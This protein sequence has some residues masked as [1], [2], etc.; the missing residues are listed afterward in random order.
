MSGNTEFILDQ[1]PHSSIPKSSG[2]PNYYYV[3]DIEKKI[4][5]NTSSVPS[6]LGGVN[7]SYLGLILSLEKYLTTM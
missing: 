3:K 2:E 1:L 4:I 5:R 7:H 6:E